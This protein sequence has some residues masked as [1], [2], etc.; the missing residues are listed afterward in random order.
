MTGTKIIL[1]F[2]AGVSIGAIAG[3]LLSPEKGSDTR[4]RILDKA[5]D[6]GSS[7]KDRMT[8]LVKGRNIFGHSRAEESSTSPKMNVNTMG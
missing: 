6:L 8:D 1:G 7:L 2:I 3:I 4:Q 5:S